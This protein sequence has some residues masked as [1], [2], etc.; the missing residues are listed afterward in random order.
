[1]SATL[2][3]SV[4]EVMVGWSERF[5][6]RDKHCNKVK[7]EKGELSVFLYW[8]IDPDLGVSATT[9]R[10]MPGGQHSLIVLLIVLSQILGG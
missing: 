10:S 6:A 9:L 5:N 7:Y 3:G 2:A 4:D 8:K 1:M